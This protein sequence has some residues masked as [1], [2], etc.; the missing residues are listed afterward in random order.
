MNAIDF[1]AATHTYSVGGTVLPSVTT[2][3]R[4]VLPVAS[5]GEQWHMDRG[6][7]HHALY[8][9]LA[10]GVKPSAIEYDPRSQPWVDGW[11][12]WQDAF[13]PQLAVS[14]IRIASVAMGYAGTADAVICIGDERWLIDYKQAAS[15]RDVI[16]LAAYDDLLT[17]NGIGVDRCAILQ[18][19]GSGSYKWME[20]KAKAR[21]KASYDWRAINRVYQLRK[22]GV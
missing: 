9:L 22:K 6:T 12:R 11:M 1:D 17:E 14:E 18:I 13:N 8:A 3:L 15:K 5:H 21:K 19:D 4:D 7:A 16:Q 10:A 20:V 2:I